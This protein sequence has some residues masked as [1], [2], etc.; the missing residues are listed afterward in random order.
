M[1]ADGKTAISPPAFFSER[2]DDDYD[3][4]RERRIVAYQ[5]WSL[6]QLADNLLVMLHVINE[7]RRVERKP[8]LALV[9]GMR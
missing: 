6:P 5:I 1:Q 4:G 7:M 2:E 3:N 9:E 8:R